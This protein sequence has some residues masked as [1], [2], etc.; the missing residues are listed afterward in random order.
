[1]IVQ[2]QGLNRDDI[3][4]VITNVV[5]NHRNKAFSYYTEED[6]EQEAWI[7]ALNKLGD[8]VPARGKNKDIKQSLENFLNTVVSRRLKNLYRDKYVVPQRTLKSDKSPGDQNKRTNLMHP[9]NLEEISEDKLHGLTSMIFENE[10]W[11]K[12]IQNLN[13]DLI[14]ILD[15]MLSGQIIKCYYRNKLLYNIKSIMEQDRE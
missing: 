6:I 7:I 8:F 15:A 14:D 1:M 12:I 2:I 10:S 9:L 5:K 13:E 4:N 11:N 3:I